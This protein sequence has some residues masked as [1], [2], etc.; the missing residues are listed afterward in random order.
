MGK[1]TDTDT[2]NTVIRTQICTQSHS[3]FFTRMNESKSQAN[4]T[5]MYTHFV[6]E[7]KTISFLLYSQIVFTFHSYRMRD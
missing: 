2:E 5:D 1:Y 4:S 3:F 6:Y 7:N